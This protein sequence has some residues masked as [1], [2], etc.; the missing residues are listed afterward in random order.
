MSLRQKRGEVH[1]N[2]REEST[3]PIRPWHEDVS[4]SQVVQTDEGGQAEGWVQ[5]QVEEFG[6]VKDQIAGEDWECEF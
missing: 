4:C 5:V 6:Q 2:E 1:V 3:Q